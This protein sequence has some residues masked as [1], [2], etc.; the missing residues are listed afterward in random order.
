M[1]HPWV[2]YPT[3][4]I[5][6]SSLFN[7][8]S[9]LDIFIIFY[10][11]KQ[12]GMILKWIDFFCSADAFPCQRSISDSFLVSLFWSPRKNFSN[13]IFQK[14]GGLVCTGRR[15]RF[16]NYQGYPD[17]ATGAGLHFIF[18]AILPRTRVILTPNLLK[19]S[20]LQQILS[21]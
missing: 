11:I 18:K 7:V 20:L 16:V 15:F 10:S 5:F 21:N 3:T 19:S 6:S 2:T 9:S 12:K 1:S 4:P 14:N 13:L 8:K 17:R